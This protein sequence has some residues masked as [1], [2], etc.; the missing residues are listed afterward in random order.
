MIYIVYKD[1]KDKEKYKDYFTRINNH[2]YNGDPEKLIK[3]YRNVFMVNYNTFP[4]QD[5]LKLID[6]SEDYVFN[7]RDDSFHFSLQY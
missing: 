6:E 5:I 3:F 2:L 7:I 1:P 4:N